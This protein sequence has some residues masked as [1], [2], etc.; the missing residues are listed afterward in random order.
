MKLLVSLGAPFSTH[1]FVSRPTKSLGR[2][3]HLF[4]S[5]SPK[6]FPSTKF[7]DAKEYARSE[8][9][10]VSIKSAEGEVLLGTWRRRDPR[11][12]LAYPLMSFVW[13]S[14][15]FRKHFTQT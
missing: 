12:G 1:S 5:S 2:L 6:V 10:T 11:P 9:G 15:V 13:K 4:Q 7:D 3:P 14:P 8:G